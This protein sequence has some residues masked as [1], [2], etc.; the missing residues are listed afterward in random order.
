MTTKESDNDNGISITGCFIAGIIM[1]AA[2]HAPEKINTLFN[3]IV[4][5]IPVERLN[6]PA[7][8]APVRRFAENK[9][10][11]ANSTGTSTE[12]EE[13]QPPKPKSERERK[14][15][16]YGL[17]L[18]ELNALG[19]SIQNDWALGEV[20]NQKN[21]GACTA[22]AISSA[23]ESLLMSRFQIEAKVDVHRFWKHYADPRMQSGL[24]T[25][26]RS[27][28]ALV[29]EVLSASKYHPFAKGASLSLTIPADGAELLHFSEVPA[30]LK[31]RFPVVFATVF[32][33]IRFDRIAVSNGFIPAH[34][35]GN[36]MAHA[37]VVSGMQTNLKKK[38]DMWIRLRNS[39]G[40]GWGQN[41]SAWMDARHCLMNGC[42][43]YAIKKIS[44]TE[45]K[46]QDDKLYS[47]NTDVEQNKETNGHY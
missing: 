31:Q 45:V 22:F 21:E 30:V 38:D 27:K 25:A 4:R 9:L 10:N 2:R 35:A 15:R 36:S 19:G 13:P 26:A 33:D 40:S 46:L 5:E 32:D 23:V 16:H 1:Q 14:E 43:F 37:M 42:D 8:V 47:R 20:K 24:D 44:L 7:A 11:A 41:G 34:F 3:R 12:R 18:A 28:H 6:S 39:W 29:A 17:A